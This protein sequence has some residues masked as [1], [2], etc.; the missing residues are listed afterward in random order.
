MSEHQKQTEFLKR[1]L[2]HDDT[3]ENHNLAERITQI[4]KDERRVQ[5]ALKVTGRFAAL[6][7]AG[8]C[9]SVVFLDYYP[10]NV[11][12][13]TSHYVAQVFCVVGLVSVICLLTF[14]YLESVHREELN[15]RHEECRER[16]I[17]FMKL[18][19]GQPIAA[20]PKDLRDNG[21]G[22]MNDKIIRV[23]AGMNGP[24]EKIESTA[25]G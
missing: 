3:A 18:R 17:S 1:C 22:E 7:A 11:L 14:A 15:R 10:E 9:Y 23:T 25:R 21:I 20:P 19:L 4:Q 12:G 6:A 16:I 2:L 13:F 24:Q 8:M 5:R